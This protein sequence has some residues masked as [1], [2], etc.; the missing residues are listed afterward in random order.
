MKQLLSSALALAAIFA[1][2]FLLLKFVFGFGADDARSL[3]QAAA[4]AD[5]RL[6]AFI[7]IAL[8]FADLFVAI[9][10]LTVSLLAGHFL[11]AALG[12]ASAAA[13][14]LAAG[15]SGYF[16]CRRLGPGL[17]LRIYKDP[18]KLRE[19]SDLFA[20]HGSLVLLICRAAP[21][22]P[23]VSCC[24]AGANR[25]PFKRFFA[26]YLLGS[27]PYAFVAAYAGSKSSLSDPAPALFAAVAL[28]LGLWLAWF[29]FLRRERRRLAAP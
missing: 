21:I 5:P 13:G 24:L 19:M 4:E 27:G 3:L 28:S 23:E 20:R 6:V 7:V 16:I 2:T 29:S 10:T 18:D 1:S 14:M 9:P 11:G 12:G 15:L 25:M 17:L 26:C 22:L 8:L